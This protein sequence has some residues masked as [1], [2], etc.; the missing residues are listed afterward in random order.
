[1]EEKLAGKHKM[2]CQCHGFF[3][4]TES[5]CHS[6]MHDT[7]HRNCA[8]CTLADSRRHS[9]MHLD[10]ARLAD[11]GPWCKH[12]DR[13]HRRLDE[14]A[15]QADRAA[16]GEMVWRW[17]DHGYWHEIAADFV[18]VHGE[19]EAFLD[20]LGFVY[21]VRDPYRFRWPGAMPDGV[22]DLVVANAAFLPALD[23]V[24]PVRT[25]RAPRA[26]GAEEA[27]RR[28]GAQ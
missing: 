15:S 22:A 8:D 7:P 1:M 21:R 11:K 26:L 25:P 28:A 18:R 27:E 2:C 3:D 13:Q 9:L 24:A 23:G 4:M 19:L 10:G 5:Y 20:E 6:V 16:R 14:L 12:I 17:R